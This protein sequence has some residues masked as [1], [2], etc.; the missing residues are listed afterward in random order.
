[1][2]LDIKLPVSKIDQASWIITGYLLGYTAAMPLVGRLSDIYGHA[3]IYQASLLIFAVGS[4]LV[5]LAQSLPWMVAA[6]VIQAVGGG[7]TIPISMAL[8]SS[9]MPPGRRGLAVGLVGAA[10][11]AGAVLGPLYRAAIIHLLDWRWIFWIDIP[12]SILLMAVL[13]LLPS[14]RE[15]GAR[16]D[17]LGGALLAGALTILS[18]AL[19]RREAFTLESGTPYLLAALGVFLVVVLVIVERRTWQPLLAP[20][21]FRS[22]SFITSNATQLLVG[23][24]LI[25]AMVNIPLN[26]N[27]PMDRDGRG[28]DS[29]RG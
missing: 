6:R 2:T 9:V 19:S 4:L 28:E 17:F 8:A 27:P 16:V 3:R 13:A 7:A 22:M 18:V 11:E 20:S 24:A 14:R 5:A 12:L 10:A 1:M 23:V 21:L 29:G 26:P 15:V 25:I